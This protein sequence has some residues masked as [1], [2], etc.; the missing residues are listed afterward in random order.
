MVS[1]PPKKWNIWLKCNFYYEKKK[2]LLATTSQ[3]TAL[4]IPQRDCLRLTHLTL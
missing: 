3:Q 2:T 4:Q 1:D